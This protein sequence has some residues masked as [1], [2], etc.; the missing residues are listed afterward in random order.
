LKSLALTKQ[1]THP[2]KG[3][4]QDGY[5]HGLSS[6]PKELQVLPSSYLYFVWWFLF[7][8]AVASS[9]A[10]DGWFLVRIVSLLPALCV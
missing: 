1:K 10:T 9:A 4:Q 2:F 8:G 7:V 5:V 6:S 3:K